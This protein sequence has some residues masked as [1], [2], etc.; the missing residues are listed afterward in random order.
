MRLCLLGDLAAGSLAHSLTVRHHGVGQD[1]VALG[2]LIL[3]IL[4]SPQPAITCSPLSSVDR[5]SD[6][7]VAGILHGGN[8]T[9]LPDLLVDTHQ[10][11]RAAV[12][13]TLDLLS[14]AAH[15][16][17]GS[18]HV[19]HTQVLLAGWLVVW[20]LNAHLLA[21]GDSA[22]EHAAEGVEAALVRGGHHLQHVHHQKACRVAAADA[23]GDC[24]IQGPFVLALH[25]GL[26]GGT[27][28][29]FSLPATCPR[30]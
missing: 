25:L 3:Q 19:L 30:R 11:H 10:C 17:H 2:I 27:T 6:M 12:W 24:I 18:L 26:L 28:W 8:G 7:D 1:E 13:Y 20:A 4:S 5:G 9:G 29:Q 23:V 21:G 16:Q 14:G 22:G 15:H